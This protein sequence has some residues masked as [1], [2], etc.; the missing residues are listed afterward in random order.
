[1]VNFLAKLNTNL[2]LTNDV[3]LSEVYNWLSSKGKFSKF[4]KIEDWRN[5][6]YGIRVGDYLLSFVASVSRGTLALRVEESK[7]SATCYY[8][9]ILSHDCLVVR[10][11]LDGGSYERS[12]KPELLDYLIGKGWFTSE[13]GMSVRNNVGIVSNSSYPLLLNL[14]QGKRSS[15]LPVVYITRNDTVKGTTSVDVTRLASAMKGIAYVVVESSKGVFDRLCKELDMK[16]VVDGRAIAIFPDG[17]R[18]TYLPPSYEYAK[19][20]KRKFEFKICEQVSKRMITLLENEKETWGNVLYQSTKEN[21]GKVE[22]EYKEFETICDGVFSMKDQEIKAKEEIIKDLKSEIEVLAGKVDYYRE[23]LKSG[24]KEYSKN[25]TYFL[26]DEE[27]FYDGEVKDCILKIL[28]KEYNT[29]EGDPNIEGSRK[30]HLLSSL[31]SLN[32]VS[33]KGKNFPKVLKK[34]FLSNS[35]RNICSSRDLKKVGFSVEEGTHNKVI[36]H[37]DRRYIFTLSKTT[38]DIRSSENAS[39][40][41]INT[42]VC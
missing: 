30:F 12:I 1:M 26:C 42:L 24:K 33:E 5:G 2:K 34:L 41:V 7:E 18:T 39:S 6:Q 13:L 29:M 16:Y 20:S 19:D 22:K 25:Q 4:D 11:T 15:S 27:E 3:F 35:L 36:F 40:I 37:N 38:S 17:K 32:T 31:L 28:E 21:Y 23:V 10:S 14:F 9:F 8:D